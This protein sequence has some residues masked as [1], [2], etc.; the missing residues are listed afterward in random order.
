MAPGEVRRATV[1]HEVAHR[2]HMHHGPEFHALVDELNGG[3]VTAARRWLKA[4]GRE[5]HRYRFI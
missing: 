5:L 3:P 1:A 2:I 4:H